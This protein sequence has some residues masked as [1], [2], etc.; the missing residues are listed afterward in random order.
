M[1]DKNNTPW[2]KLCSPDPF[3]SLSNLHLDH[4]Y[5]SGKKNLKSDRFLNEAGSIK[6]RLNF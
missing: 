1:E 5:T 3:L 6:C 2:R 4:N